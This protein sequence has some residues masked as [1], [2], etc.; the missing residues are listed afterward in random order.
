MLQTCLGWIACLFGRHQWEQGPN[1]HYILNDS[2]I[3][4]YQ[5]ARCGRSKS[6]R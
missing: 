5:C 2:G 1:Y 3:R 6:T 4:F